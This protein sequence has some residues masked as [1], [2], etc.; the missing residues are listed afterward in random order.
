MARPGRFLDFDYAFR[1]CGAV[2]QPTDDEGQPIAAC[3][4][5][6]TAA[7][8]QY[9][10]NEL[11]SE[12]YSIGSSLPGDMVSGFSWQ[13]LEYKAIGLVG[14]QL[15][16]RGG[17][18][19]ATEGCTSARRLTVNLRCPQWLN[20][21]YPDAL[22]AVAQPNTSATL[23]PNPPANVRGSTRVPSV[24]LVR[25]RIDSPCDWEV[26]IDSVYACPVECLPAE[27]A[28]TPP[29]SD[30][31]TEVPVCGGRGICRDLF[32]LDDD[33]APQ[34]GCICQQDAAGTLCMEGQNNQRMSDSVDERACGGEA[35]CPASF[36]CSPHVCC[37]FVFGFFILHSL[38]LLCV[39][40]QQRIQT[41]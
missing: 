27:F 5:K 9:H 37:S 4:A 34:V 38:V 20:G 23:F 30:V 21:K 18:A 24:G 29:G 16:F 6:S 10:G 33:K 3:A 1:L 31:P 19:D 15:R 14:V 39:W 25:E 2:P 17:D 28:T 40:L 7:A 35:F 13:P 36:T 32:T 22:T 26:D 41:S 12:C 11:T 8:L